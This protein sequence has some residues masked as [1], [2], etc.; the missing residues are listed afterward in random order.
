MQEACRCDRLSVRFMNCRAVAT[1]VK[2]DWNFM[3]VCFHSDEVVTPPGH[4]AELIS[5]TAPRMD[6]RDGLCRDACV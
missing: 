2:V 3:A 4:N 5:G 1:D 6:G